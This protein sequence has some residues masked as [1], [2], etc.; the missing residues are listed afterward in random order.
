V[1]GR[2]SQF[3]SSLDAHVAICAA[4]SSASLV[5]LSELVARSRSTHQVGGLVGGELLL[6]APAER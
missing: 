4:R 1:G 6:S 3:G 2:L 5:G